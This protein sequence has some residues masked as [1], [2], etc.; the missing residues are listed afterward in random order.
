MK[1]FMVVLDRG[2]ER[3]CKVRRDKIQLRQKMKL[4]NS[5]FYILVLAFGQAA[6]GPLELP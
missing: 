6:P 5:L 1:N 4:I 3:S 2:R